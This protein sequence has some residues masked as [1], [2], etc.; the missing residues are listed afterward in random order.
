VLARATTDCLPAC[1]PACLSQI[2]E[3]PLVV[4]PSKYL[5]TMDAVSKCWKTVPPESDSLLIQEPDGI[6]WAIAKECMEQIPMEIQNAL[7]FFHS[8]LSHVRDF[9][10][11]AIPTNNVQFK[12]NRMNKKVI[13]QL[14]WSRFERP[15]VLPGTDVNDQEMDM[16]L[17]MQQRASIGDGKLTSDVPALKIR[18]GFTGTY[19]ACH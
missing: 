3:D 4:I 13:T 7:Y 19:F 2:Y 17:E 16:N 5:Q 11:Y 10:R 6:T 8:L 12:R 1:L 18:L 15:P 14:Q 9:N